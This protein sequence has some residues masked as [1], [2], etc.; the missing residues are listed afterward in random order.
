MEDEEIKGGRN[1]EF[2]AAEKRE[3]KGRNEEESRERE[4]PFGGS[5][6]HSEGKEFR[7]R[8]ELQ[9][10][11]LFVQTRDNKQGTPF[12]ESRRK[13]KRAMTRLL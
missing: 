7:R 5:S 4:L 8:G 2:E 13:K 9:G 6:K 12:G 3:N 10:R 1:R 11:K